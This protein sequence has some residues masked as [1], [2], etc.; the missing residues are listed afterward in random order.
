ML[1]NTTP[2]IATSSSTETI[3]NGSRY[4]VNSNLPSGDRAAFGRAAIRR[5]T[6]RACSRLVRKMARIA[7]AEMS[8]PQAELLDPAPFLR[9]Q[10]QQHDHKQ[11]QDHHRARIDQH[12]HRG[13]EER[14]QQDEQPGQR[15]DGQ[16]QEHRAGDRVAAERIGHDQKAK[17]QGQERKNIESSA[18]C[19]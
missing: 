19:I 8:P 2:T 13:E 16:H 4:W 11:E 9:L 17:H 1:S 14:V 12:L 15:N 7:P 6:Q 18:S 10:I 3:S 5:G